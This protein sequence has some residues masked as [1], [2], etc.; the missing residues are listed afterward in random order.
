MFFRI[1]NVVVKKP[2]VTEDLHSSLY[3]ANTF[4]IL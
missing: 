1:P 4:A 3:K 2:T